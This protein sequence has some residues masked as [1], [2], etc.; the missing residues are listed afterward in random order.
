MTFSHALATRPEP[1]QTELVRALAELGL[2]AVSLPAFRFEARPVPA[3]LVTR[4]RN[5]LLIF[6][7]PRA[8][9][10]GLAA[11]G[12]AL[13]GTA[14]AAAIGPATQAALAKHGVH[15]LQ[16]PGNRHDSEALLAMLDDGIAPGRALIFAAPGGREALERGLTER[17]WQVAL[18]PVYRRVLLAPAPMEADRLTHAS[19][20]LSLWTSGTAMRHVLQGL[21]EAARAA[22]LRGTAIVA[23]ERLASLAWERGFDA[24][25]TAE[26]AS[27]TALLAAARACVEADAP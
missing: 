24:V 27:N 5:A 25:V 11:L 7:S 8:V 26:G 4:A 3:D 6:T 12:G 16:A 14:R 1:Q 10:F 18:A 2:E 13:P 22:V 15:A 9:T 19:R 21:P 17:G 20:V 23:S